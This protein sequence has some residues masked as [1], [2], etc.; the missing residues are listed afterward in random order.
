M[1]LS[2][3]QSN[4]PANWAVT[5]EYD[6]IKIPG[7]DSRVVICTIDTFNGTEKGRYDIKVRATA[8]NGFISESWLNTSLIKDFENET[9]EL[10]D[11]IQIHYIGMTQ[12]GE[13]FDTSVFDA[14]NNT[15]LPKD[16][17]WTPKQTY[18]PLNIVA[19]P[20]E[21]DNEDDKKKYLISIIGVWEGV[22]DMKVYETKVVRIPPEKAYTYEGNEGHHLYGETL[23]FEIT[24]VS[25]DN[26]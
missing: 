4:L 25:I 16:P 17:R 1:T 7:F 8:G 2:Y 13:I 26:P 18:E 22:Q 12:N 5:F 9:V 10:N 11:L 23:I 3:T 19:G 6:H 20:D 21:P 14:A 15:D 24:L